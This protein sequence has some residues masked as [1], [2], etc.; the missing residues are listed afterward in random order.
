MMTEQVNIGG[1]RS[2][3]YNPAP[4]LAEIRR[5]KLRGVPAGV[6]WIARMAGI[7]IATV[8]RVRRGKASL[9]AVGKVCKVLEIDPESVLCGEGAAAEDPLTATAREPS[10]RPSCAQPA[11]LREARAQAKA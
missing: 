4:I 2:R 1:V 6:V 9:T 5:R 8:S 3:Q 11:L 10:A 7:S